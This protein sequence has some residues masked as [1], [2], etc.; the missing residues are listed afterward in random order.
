LPKEYAEIEQT[1]APVA[2][3]TMTDW[4]KKTGIK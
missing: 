1:I 4:I 3:E 2:L